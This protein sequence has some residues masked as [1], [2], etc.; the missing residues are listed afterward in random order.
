MT[1]VLVRLWKTPAESREN[2]SASK[3]RHWVLG[4]SR[5]LGFTDYEQ[6]TATK[7]TRHKKFLSDMEKVVPWQRL[8]EIIEPHYSYAF[9]G[10]DAASQDSMPKS[11]SLS[12]QQAVLCIADSGIGQ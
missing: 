11:T 4:G 3:G 7:R 10:Q 2:G 1:D 9:R 8:L 12:D 5:P 6:T